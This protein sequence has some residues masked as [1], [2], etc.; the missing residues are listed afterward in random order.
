MKYF[1]QLAYIWFT[2]PILLLR[3][4]GE[5]LE[6]LRLFCCAHALVAKHAWN[7]LRVM[8]VGGWNP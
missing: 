3:S 1:Y 5:R 7:W 8:F 6:I 4:T 2:L